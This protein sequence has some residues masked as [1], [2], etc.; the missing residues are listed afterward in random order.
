MASIGISGV[1]VGS[2]GLISRISK[3]VSEGCDSVVGCTSSTT[4]FF[5]SHRP[6]ILFFFP[7]DPLDCDREE[8]R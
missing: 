3:L 7:V 6:E 5:S 2:S 4:F 8:L 1:G